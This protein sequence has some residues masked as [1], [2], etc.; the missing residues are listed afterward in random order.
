MLRVAICDDLPEQ[1]ALIENAAR[2]YFKSIKEVV[3]ILTFHN[4]MDFLDAFEVKGHFD[5]ALLDIC[6]P[7]ILGTDIAAE[8]RKAKSRCEIV[9]LSTSDEFAVEAFAVQ[10]AHYLVKPFT[11][12]EFNAALNR[13]MDSIRQRHSHKIIFRLVGGGIQ[14]EEVN[15]ILFSQSNGHVQQI[16]LKDGS[17][18]ETRQSLNSLW[19]TLEDIAPGQFVSPSK[20][21]LVNQAAIHVIKNN[22]IEVGGHHIPLSKRK[23]RQFQEE[24]FQYIFS[25]NAY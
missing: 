11:Q 4:A 16:Y 3:E 18:V 1:A 23:Y 6:M 24:Y 22:D 9:F 19:D 7:G 17:S 12:A 8:M 20:G 10:A 15:H 5:I 21:Y 25:K 2:T 13:V 14:V